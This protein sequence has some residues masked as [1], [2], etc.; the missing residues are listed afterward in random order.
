[1][2]NTLANSL[3]QY[4]LAFYLKTNVSE[5]RESKTVHSMK[6]I[7][8]IAILFLFLFVLGHFAN[9]KNILFMLDICGF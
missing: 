6:V 5:K 9:Q 3:V 7:I 4:K 2:Q 8:A 1:M